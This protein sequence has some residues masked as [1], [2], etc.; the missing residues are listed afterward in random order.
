[1]MAKTKNEPTMK[2]IADKHKKGWTFIDDGKG[3]KVV[4]RRK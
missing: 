1:M 2:E 3:T 4:K